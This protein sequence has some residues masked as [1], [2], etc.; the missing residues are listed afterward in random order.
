MDT[1]GEQQLKR[2]QSGS[3]RPLLPSAGLLKLV[4][5]GA[6]LVAEKEK[7]VKL[8]VLKAASYDGVFIIAITSDNHP[9]GVLVAQTREKHK[10][11]NAQ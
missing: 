9:P 10:T 7:R 4:N 6:V 2:M 5:E 3:S 11:W 1:I 8:V